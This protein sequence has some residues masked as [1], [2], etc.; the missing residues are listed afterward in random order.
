MST[1]NSSL[2]IEAPGSESRAE[3]RIVKADRSLLRMVF[4]GLMLFCALVLRGI[5]EMA[6]A[7]KVA[8]ATARVDPAAAK[9]QI[10][11]LLDGFLLG[12]TGIMTVGGLYLGIKGWRIW[13][14]SQ[15]PVPGT[16][17]VMDTPI[18]R[19]TQARRRAVVGWVFAV[20]L[21]LGAYL[22]P[23][24]GREAILDRIYLPQDSDAVPDTV[25]DPDTPEA[26]S[27]PVG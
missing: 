16:R 15:F 8:R 2:H 5:Y 9:I 11:N 12:M 4:L 18:V 13:Q 10:L 3:H 26:G 27:I 21:L 17:V 6:Q 25:F 7:F 24:L 1:E 23:S 20:G 22:L 19:G 14:A